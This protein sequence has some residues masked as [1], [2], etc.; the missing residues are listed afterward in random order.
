VNK[1]QSSFWLIGLILLIILL[2]G[3][4]VPRSDNAAGDV[5][6][7]TNV[8]PS[9]PPT[10]AP[11]STTAANA[12]VM[13]AAPAVQPDL[14]LRLEP[15][16]QLVNVD[17]TTVMQIRLDNAVNLTVIDLQLRFNP[18]LL[19]VL[20]ADE[21]RDGIQIQ[22][23][24]FINPADVIT[25]QVD[26]GAGVITYYATP[27][28]AN[29]SG[30][31]AAITFRGKN[32]GVTDISFTLIDLSSQGEPVT[33][34][35]PAPGRITVNPGIGP[36]ATFTP[37]PLPPTLP[38][39]FTPPP[40]VVAGTPTPTFTPSATPTPTPTNTPA[41]PAVS[42]PPHATLGECYRVQPGETLYSLGQKFGIDR[43][44][45]NLANDLHPP[46]HIYP[47]Q[48]LFMPTQY[49]RGPNVYL[50]KPG[51]TLTMIAD[52]CQLDVGFL[53]QVNNQPV[54][55]NLQDIG[56]VIIPRPP[57]PPPS[58]YPYPPPGPGTVWPPPC[59]PTG[60]CW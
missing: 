35:P 49:G 58:R 20:D 15:L 5:A 37:T 16:T 14:V 45:I 6:N 44:F 60:R 11:Q 26:N 38:P 51:D 4:E 17:E 39:T 2:S 53:A 31:L 1:L 34:P 43:N 40:V 57:F 50:V 9:A 47:Q 10:L 36:T 56:Y 22:L 33:V 24:N 25:N 32:P 13:L 59:W 42:I 30:L 46:G 21:A 55:A 52:A 41:A 23:G 48:V 27:I 19:E 29:G 54:N 12:A 7:L 28:S 18:T 3:C 8:P